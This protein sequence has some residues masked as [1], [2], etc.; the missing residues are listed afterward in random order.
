MRSRLFAVGC[1]LV[2]RE[3]ASAMVTITSHLV[4]PPFEDTGDWFNREEGWTSARTGHCVLGFIIVWEF[5]TPATLAHIR[6]SLA[7]S[8][9]LFA[10]LAFT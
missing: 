1:L 5:L 10:P 8:R 9:R 2:I 4:N 7:R 6:T 3:C